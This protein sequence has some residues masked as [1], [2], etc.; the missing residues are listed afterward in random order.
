MRAMRYRARYRQYRI[1]DGEGGNMADAAGC[2]RV[3]QEVAIAAFLPAIVG[4]FAGVLMRRHSR[5]IGGH[6]MVM[7]GRRIRTK[8]L[9][10]LRDRGRD[11][12]QQDRKQPQ[13]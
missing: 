5:R 8:G 11:G 10:N 13:P 4:R 9:T 12:D 3:V 1:G 6:E 2:G 7:R